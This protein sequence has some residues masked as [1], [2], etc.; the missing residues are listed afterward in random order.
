M[1]AVETEKLMERDTVKEKPAGSSNGWYG[2][3]RE[4]N[5]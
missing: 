3:M 5:E 4:R 1:V 2:V